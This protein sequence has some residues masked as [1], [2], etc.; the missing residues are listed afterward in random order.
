MEVAI[1]L[2][3]E[4]E[5]IFE[6]AWKYKAIDSDT[7]YA[8]LPRIFDGV[9]NIHLRVSM[10]QFHLFIDDI[11]TGQRCPHCAVKGG[12]GGYDCCGKA[13]EQDEAAADEAWFRDRD[14]EGGK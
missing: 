3:P 1:A 7:L 14:I 2:D 9:D 6:D 4:I 8:E 12:T 13:I 11:R 10:T 5:A